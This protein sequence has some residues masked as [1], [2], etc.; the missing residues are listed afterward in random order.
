MKPYQNERIENAIA[1]FASQHCKRTGKD[2]YSMHIYKYLAFFEFRQLEKTGDMPLGLHYIAMERGPVPDEIYT[3]IKTIRSSL[4]KIISEG[5]NH[6]RFSSLKAPDLDYFSDEE[7]DEMNN[8]IDFFAQKWVTTNVMSDATHQAILAW[9][10]TWKERPN[11]LIDP[12]TAFEN[13][14][15]KPV[16]LLTPSEEHFLISRSLQSVDCI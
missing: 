5:E 13:I 9:R 8:L 10:K 14:L 2:P 3:N 15:S 1:F 16:D 6:Y 7:I 12:L 4:Y 11:S